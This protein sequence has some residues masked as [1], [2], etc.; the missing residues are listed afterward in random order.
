MIVDLQNLTPIKTVEKVWGRELWLVNNSDY[1]SKILEIKPG[2]Q[3]SL[4]FH[5]IKHETFVILRGAVYFECRSANTGKTEILIPGDTRDLPAYTPHRF[6][7][8]IESAI[9]EIST[10]H[11]DEDVV[12]LEE[13]R[14]INEHNPRDIK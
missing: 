10:T 3:C 9:L 4:H 8:E 12:R 13:S 2:Y 11:S 7:S 6:A 1:C 14:K 5:K